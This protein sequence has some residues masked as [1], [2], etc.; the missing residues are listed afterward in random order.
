[1]SLTEYVEHLNAIEAKASA[2]AETIVPDES[3]DDISPAGL[4][5]ILERAGDIRREV[6][7]AA[8]DLQ[9]PRQVAELHELI[10]EWH[11]D[12]TNI[13]ADLAARV[14]VTPDTEDGWT[15]LSDSPEMAAYRDAIA[16]G[17]IICDDFQD[18]LD[19]TEA[20]GA[21]EDV[22]WIPS[23]MSEVVEAV[24]GCAWFPDEPQNVYR[25]PPPAATG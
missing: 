24:L 3:T 18:Q 10:F 9:P 17:K 25:W 6:Q 22:P 19:A 16:E 15:Q 12:F 4:Q 2:E 14:G 13:E 23:D 7:I 1:M 20:R 11:R 5:A 21:F 8:D